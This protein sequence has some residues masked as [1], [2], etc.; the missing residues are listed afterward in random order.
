MKTTISELRKVIKQLIKEEIT[1]NESLFG[2][3][4]QPKPL[5]PYKPSMMDRFKLG[6]KKAFGAENE[7]HRNL[8]N[9]LLLQLTHPDTQ[10]WNV[11]KVGN[12]AT[13]DTAM[14]KLFVSCNP[15]SPQLSLSRQGKEIELEL[16]NKAEACQE[17]YDLLQQ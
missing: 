8:L 15:Q 14:G 7:E 17:I 12:D 10:A 5:T 16:E 13:A 11:V 4:T 1:S 2:P 9:K 6:V 3:P